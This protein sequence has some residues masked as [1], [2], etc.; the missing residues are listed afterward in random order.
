MEKP[1]RK[2]FNADWEREARNW[3]AWARTPGHDSYWEYSPAFFEI[4][5]APG[6]GTLE[7]GCGEG[8]VARDLARRG[9]RVCGIDASPTL[10]EAA[11][12][13]DPDGDYRVADAADL[14]FAAGSFDTAVAYNSLMDIEDLGGA[15][16][17]AARV[18]TDAGRLCIC[19]LH[20]MADAGRFQTRAPD[21][22]F[23]IAGS[24]LESRQIV[25]P[26]A[27]DGL[28]ITF[29]GWRHPLQTYARALEDA[30]F[31]IE[32]LREP[33]QTPEVVAGDVTEGRWRRLPLFLFLRAVKAR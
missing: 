25:E 3:I 13:A 27:R 30:G 6:Q 32:C 12:E 21:A 23:V 4:V 2:T 1:A 11:C 7:I 26:F 19:I 28:A 14:P 5:P 33:A 22:P 20:P 16:R 17:E 10:I 31:L 9:H 24:Y 8:R 18:L 15:V 29:H